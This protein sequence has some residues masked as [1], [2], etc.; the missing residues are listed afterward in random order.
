MMTFIVTIRRDDGSHISELL[1]AD[2]KQE[3]WMIA[4]ETYGSQVHAIHG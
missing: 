2:T 4:T 1:E 3:A